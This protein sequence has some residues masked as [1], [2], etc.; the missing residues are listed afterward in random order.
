[1]HP[2]TSQYLPPPLLTFHSN[3]HLTHFPP[4]RHSTGM[5]SHPWAW[6]CI[7][8]Q[9]A[10]CEREGGEKD[11]QII[12]SSRCAARQIMALMWTDFWWIYITV[13][14]AGSGGK[15]QSRGHTHYHIH[16]QPKPD[17]EVVQLSQWIQCFISPLQEVKLGPLGLQI[18]HI[19][20]REFHRK[21]VILFFFSHSM[22]M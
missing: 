10:C 15:G 1:M 4:A 8:L 20:I 9:L 6:P 14:S 18:P 19:V 16:T 2:S 17:A 7:T 5:F 3:F 13:N 11:N 21:K 22:Q 12:T